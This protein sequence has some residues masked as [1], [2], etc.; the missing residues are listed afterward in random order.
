MVVLSGWMTSARALCVEAY[1]NANIPGCGGM[2]MEY[3]R[4][5]TPWSTRKKT[6]EQEELSAVG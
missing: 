4:L 1:G 6:R 3:Q 2:T 5:S